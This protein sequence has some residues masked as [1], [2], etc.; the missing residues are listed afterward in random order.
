MKSIQLT[1]GLLALVDD[2]VYEELSRFNWYAAASG[3]TF[4]AVRHIGTGNRN[5]AR[6]HRQILGIDSPSIEVDHR[7]GNGLNNQRHNLRIANKTQNQHNRGRQRNNS[8][9]FKGVTFSK[10]DKCWMAYIKLSGR[11]RHLGNFDDP[12]MAALAYD[13]AARKH[14]G[15]FA[16]T[17]GTLG[18][19][20]NPH[21]EEE[22][23]DRNNRNNPIVHRS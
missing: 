19:F 20:W 8:T 23:N 6:M 11:Q 1:K 21:W 18:N 5:V 4:Y 7:D 17:N 2:D 9:G 13:E 15:E 12:R 16:R 3:E 14:F 10:R 22:T